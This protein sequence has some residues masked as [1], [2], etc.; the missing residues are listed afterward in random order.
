VLQLAAI[1]HEIQFQS[2]EVVYRRNE[3]PEALF[4]IVSGEVD[5]TAPDRE[6]VTVG[7]GETFG[8]LDLLRSQLRSRDATASSQAHVLIIE[9]EDF[10]DLLATNVEIVRALFR[11]LTLPIKDL[12]GELR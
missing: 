11:Q 6:P 9:A 2:D 7:P 10:F 5:L 12:P 1:S 3:P 8:V 4:C